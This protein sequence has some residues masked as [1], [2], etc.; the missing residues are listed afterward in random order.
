MAKKRKE[1]DRRPVGIYVT[2]AKSGPLAYQLYEVTYFTGAG[3][4]GDPTRFETVIEKGEYI[5]CWPGMR[6]VNPTPKEK[7]KEKANAKF[8]RPDLDYYIRAAALMLEPVARA[9]WDAD[10]PLPPK[11]PKKGKKRG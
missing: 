2:V 10:K 6:V 8:H 5:H 4:K 9:C 7:A 3:T 11:G 1:T